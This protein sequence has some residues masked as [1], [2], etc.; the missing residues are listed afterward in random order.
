MVPV[1]NRYT[2][3]SRQQDELTT[4][5]VS[6]PSNIRYPAKNT[7]FR[8]CKSIG[9]IQTKKTTPIQQLRSSVPLPY[10][11]HNPQ[12]REESKSESVSDIHYI[13]TIVNGLTKVH[14]T[15]KSETDDKKTKKTTPLQ[16]LRSSV[17]HPYSE[18][19]PPKLRRK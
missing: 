5:E 8:N 7:T 3:F 10:S 17:P 1:K 12:S 9:E 2:I 11:E 13:P 14:H 16:Q 18:H 4:K 19:N 15:P 6:S